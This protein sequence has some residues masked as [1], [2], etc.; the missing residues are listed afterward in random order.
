MTIKG[1]GEPPQRARA[2]SRSKGSHHHQQEGQY[3]QMQLIF[4]IFLK[5]RLMSRI[6]HCSSNRSTIDFSKTWACTCS[7]PLLFWVNQHHQP[8][9]NEGQEYKGLD[10]QGCQNADR[11]FIQSQGRDNVS[12]YERVCESVF[13][14]VIPGT[15]LAHWTL[16]RLSMPTYGAVGC[17]AELARSG[18]G[19]ERV[20]TGW[21]NAWG[22]PL[23]RDTLPEW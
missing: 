12:K 19:G 2:I 9:E 17:E 13:H 20:G 14:L 21:R 15:W 16:S 22:V 23:W 1:Q 8:R 4:W 11:H 5:R 10:N 3:F 18:R 6:C 7:R